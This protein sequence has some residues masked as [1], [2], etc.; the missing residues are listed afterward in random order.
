MTASPS[1]S[2]KLVLSDPA[3]E[4]VAAWKAQF[5][6]RPEVEIHERSIFEA[7]A[8]AILLPGNSFG[9]LESGLGLETLERYGWGVEEALRQRIRGDFD[10]ELLVGQ[11]VVL[12]LDAVPRAMV[13]TPIFRTPRRLEGTVNVYLAVR[14]A[15]LAWRRQAGAAAI[16]IPALGLDPGGLHP[17]ISARQIRY[18]YEVVCGLRG[19]GDKNLT[20]QMRREKKLAQV[21]GE[22]REDGDE[23]GPAAPGPP[24][25]GCPPGA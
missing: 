4:A 19:P 25:V 1:V 10:G 24:A 12:R 7:P 22:G 11:A 21:P 15:L 23:A 16:A 5:L 2:V 6:N 14:G 13:Y 17:L 20:Q 3:A 18:A 8:E 9:F